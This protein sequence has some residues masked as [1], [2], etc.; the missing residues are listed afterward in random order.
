MADNTIIARSVKLLLTAAPKGSEIILFGSRSRCDAAESS[1][2]DFL[3]VEPQVIGRLAEAARLA[4]VLRP[5]RVP[6]DVVV[7]SRQVFE[8]WKDTPNTVIYEAA[9]EGRVF[10]EVA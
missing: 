4:R 3:V 1:D 5:L 7:V 6:A 8:E 10:R 2:F 9:R